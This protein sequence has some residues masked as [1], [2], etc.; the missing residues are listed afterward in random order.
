MRRQADGVASSACFF[1]SQRDRF[2][3][4]LEMSQGDRF[5]DSSCSKMSQG[6]RFLDSSCSE[7]HD[8]VCMGNQDVIHL[9]C[10]Q[11]VTVLFDIK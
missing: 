6:D 10:S 9:V 2:L 8:P 5:L 11:I 3:D 4:S 7:K 1:M